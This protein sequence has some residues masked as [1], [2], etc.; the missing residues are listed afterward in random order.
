[1]S[2]A[3]KVLTHRAL[4]RRHLIGLVLLAV[5][6]VW[7][8]LWGATSYR[9]NR[10]MDSWL[11]AARTNEIGV[12]YEDRY[13]NGTLFSIHLHLD[14]LSVTGRD[15]SSLRAEESVF[16]LSLLDW[17]D[18]SGKL[19]HGVKG[20]IG[21]I[22]FSAD[23]IK[24]GVSIPQK[25]AQSHKETGLAL[26][27]H[28]YGLSFET[29]SP[30][31]FDNRIEESMIDLR[32]MG[33]VPDFRNRDS[34]KVWSENGGVIELDRL[35]FRWGP[36]I[37]TGNGTLSLDPSL[38]PEGAFSGRIEGIDEAIARLAE[39]GMIDKRQEAMI[40]SSLQVQ[41][42]PSGLTGAS[43]PIVPITM[44]A[45]GLYLGPVKLTALPTITW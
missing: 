44:Q 24:L 37:A 42:R 8:A 7:A 13:T 33:V 23:A 43:A 15:G 4:R 6:V 9:F 12:N 5:F 40:R 29:K 21:D 20:T 1:M 11:A 35:F 14:G 32:I 18:V 31:L 19:R 17:S 16:Y 30:L 38:Q 34:V 10:A 3:A 25:P 26:W 36:V 45:G 22:P 2:F 41:G 39:K 28:P 27:L